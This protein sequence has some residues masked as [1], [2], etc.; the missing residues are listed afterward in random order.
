MGFLSL[1]KYLVQCRREINKRRRRPSHRRYT[2]IDEYATNIFLLCIHNNGAVSIIFIKEEIF[3]FPRINRI[4]HKT[5]RIIIRDFF[6]KY[7]QVCTTQKCFIRQENGQSVYST[8]DECGMRRYFLMHDD[9]GG[10]VMKKN[11]FLTLT[12]DTR[13]R[14]AA[15]LQFFSDY[16]YQTQMTSY[17]NRFVI[18]KLSTPLRGKLKKKKKRFHDGLNIVRP[19]LLFKCSCYT[20]TFEDIFF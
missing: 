10:N 8:V 12:V 4:K 13:H 5:V 17:P 7:C 9:N 20:V 18:I 11:E 16:T 1:S 2:D 19:F 6:Y 14:L 15:P 3:Y